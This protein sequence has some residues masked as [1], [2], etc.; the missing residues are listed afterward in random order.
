[1]FSQQRF[2][3]ILKTARKYRLTEKDKSYQSNTNYIPI[4][5]LYIES[6][7]WGEGNIA[8]DKFLNSIQSHLQTQDVFNNT[9]LR[10][11][12]EVLKTYV[13]EFSLI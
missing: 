10:T 13:P 2:E 6:A 1:L 11:F 8:Q 4:I 7:H 3:K 12:V 5:P 9:T